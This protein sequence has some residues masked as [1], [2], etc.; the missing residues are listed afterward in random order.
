MSQRPFCLL[1]SLLFCCHLQAQQISFSPMRLF[2]KGAPGETV[3]ETITI[4]NTTGQP[5]EF[6]LSLK[7]WNRDSLGIKHYFPANSL[8]HSN[9][10]SISLPQTSFIVTPGEK[11]T[12]TVNLRIPPADTQKT[13]SNSMLF[14]TQVNAPPADATGKP[15]IGIRVSME[16]GIQLF[17]TPQAAE[18]G[19]FQFLA[20][21]YEPWYIK[22]SMAHRLVVK[23]QNT[24]R[25]HK[26]GFIRFELTNKQTG[27]EIRPAP[28]PI[29]IAPQSDQVVY[30]PLGK[31]P[32]GDY[33]AVAILDA[34][35]EYEL[36][37]AE[38]NI[39]VEE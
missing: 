35:A 9:A 25:V 10:K 6:L 11:K 3:S 7:D 34:G 16:F 14:F 17:Y 30:C 28:V 2:F 31:L 22:D 33:L 26:D 39:H 24:G 1:L 32:P 8:P 38:K 5:Y 36:K 20:F 12:Y 19:T 15:G 18:K 21:N 27:A 23:Y 29:A 37:V 13:A 4:A